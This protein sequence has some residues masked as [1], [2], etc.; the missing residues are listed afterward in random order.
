M[1][2]LIQTQHLYDRTP[3]GIMIPAGSTTDASSFAKT[4]VLRMKLAGRELIDLFRKHGLDPK[5]STS[6]MTFVEDTARLSDALLCAKDDDTSYS[7]IFSTLQLSRIVEA[8]DSIADDPSL[9]RLLSELLD[10]TLNLLD[11][12]R[13][14]A[15]DTLWELELHKALR[16]NGVHVVFGEPDLLLAANQGHIGVACKKLYSDAN[17]S[18]VLSGAVGQI[19][20]SVKLGLVAINIDDLL[21]EGVILKAP[22]EG[23]AAGILNRRIAN[24]MS[25]HERHLRHYMEP[26]RTIAIL[27]SCAVLAELEQSEPRFCTFRQ[28]VAW[29]IPSI[30]PQIDSEFSSVV[31]A[32]RANRTHS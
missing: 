14:K 17:L 12:S 19:E 26:G 11:R 28:T 27:V 21:P 31:S 5:R 9:P 32:F 22:N 20:R 29:H 8:V 6:F 1:N 7:Q 15:K 30:S 24:F 23:T 4:S 18:K 10:G 16:L 2:R 13:S 25:N 3:A